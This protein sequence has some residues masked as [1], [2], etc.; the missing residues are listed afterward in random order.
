MSWVEPSLKKGKI[1]AELLKLASKMLDWKK[2]QSF[3]WCVDFCLA[4]MVLNRITK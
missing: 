1:G 3:I 4:I 2:T